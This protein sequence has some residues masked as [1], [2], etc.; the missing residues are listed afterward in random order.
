MCEE[1]R[2]TSIVTYRQKK[3]RPAKKLS[4]P[5]SIFFFPKGNLPSAFRGEVQV[6]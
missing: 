2:R 6:C 1:M 3:S 4:F 5:L